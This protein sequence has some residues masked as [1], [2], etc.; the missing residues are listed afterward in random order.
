MHQQ[1]IWDL[2][3]PN[4]NNYRQKPLRELS[5]LNWKKGKILDLG[6]GNCRNLIPFKDLECY[7]LDF[8]KSMLEQSKKFSKKHNFKVSLTQSD[9]EK[10]LPYKSSSFNYV[11]AIASL[12]HLSNPEFTI[13]EISRILKKNGEVYITVWNKLQPKFLFRK[14]RTLIPW[15]QKSQTLMRYYHFIGYLE[16]KSL[17]RK[18]NF[19]I[20]KSG[21]GK[22]ITFHVR[23]DKI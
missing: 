7:G 9:L 12:H 6:C 2:I 23:L 15:K 1:K 16:L 11:L 18:N 8:S 19:T 5:K 17:L 4:W 20:L 3:A 14:K 21:F 13:K 22:N 10:K